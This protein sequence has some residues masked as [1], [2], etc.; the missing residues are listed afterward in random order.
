MEGDEKTR[1]KGKTN[2]GA[3]QD[4]PLS[5]IIF[6]IWMAPIIKKIEIAIREVVPYDNE[7]LSY[8]DDL[9]VNI[10]N[11]NRIHIDMELL[12]KR[13]N[14]VVNWLAKENHLPLKKSKYEMRVLRKK[15]RK[16]NKD[17]KWVK[18]IGIIMDESLSFKEHWKSRIAKARKMLG[19]LNG[20]GNSM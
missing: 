9:H 3:L 14:K 8:V 17:V 16:K 5:P 20:L 18:W 10:C 4:S 7:L 19:Q 1:W 13:I 2:L 11:W 6:L 12:L 15:R